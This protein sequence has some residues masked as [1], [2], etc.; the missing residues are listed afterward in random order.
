MEDGR[1]KLEDGSWKMEVGS[2][3]MEVGRWKLEDGSWKT[4]LIFVGTYKDN[5]FGEVTITEKKGKLYFASTRSK[6][7]VN[8]IFYYKDNALAVKWNIRSFHADVFINFDPNENGTITH[9]KMDVISP[10]TDFSYD[11]QD[12]DFERVK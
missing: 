11:F 3:K 1:W 8:E 5:W 6:R 12:L 2:W 9:F 10:M 7:L 4:E